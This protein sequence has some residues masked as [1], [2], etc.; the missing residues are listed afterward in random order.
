[1]SEPSKE[2]LDDL[3][4]Q[5]DEIDSRL[6]QLLD[7]RAKLAQA[8]G[9]LKGQ[10]GQPFFIPEREHAIYKKLAL[11]HTTAL[12]PR[13]LAAIFREIISAAR[14]SERPLTVAYWGPPGSFSEM[15][16]AKTFGNSAR[17]QECRSITDVFYAVE[18]TQ[19]DYGVAP[20]ENS[21]AGVV[22]ETLDMF[23]QTNVKIC[24]ETI[25]A[26]HHFLAGGAKALADVKRVYAGPQPA[27]QCRKWL[28]ANLPNAELIEVTPTSAS[29]QRAVDDPEGAAIVNQLAIERYKLNLIAE[30]IEDSASNATRF[31]VLGQNEPVRTGQDKTSLMFNLK[32]RPG[33]L[34][35]VLGAFVR[36][37]VNL[38]MIESRP[39]QRSSF[40][41][42]FYVDCAGHRTDEHVASAVE[43]IKQRALETV[44]LGSYPSSDPKLVGALE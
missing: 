4:R 29:A 44:V 35:E 3:R 37:N 41:Y 39:A 34:Y 33:E 14:D 30:H 25:L 43:E 12:T 24:A 22:P 9:E 18:R 21:T 15:A 20:V 40:E 19:C 7:D 5:I 23:P 16:A 11:A 26:V 2:E 8:I 36:H 13:H 10:S 42:I 32:N 28:Q 17:M 27:N 1:M 38:L 6:I 31:V